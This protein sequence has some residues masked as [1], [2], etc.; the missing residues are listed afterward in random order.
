MNYSRA[1]L[2]RK[3]RAL[4]GK[5]RRRI[6]KLNIIVCI[7]LITS[8][9][10]VVSLGINMGLGTLQGI[11]ASAPEI[12]KI[13]VTPSGFSTFV[14]DTQG[15]QTAKLV[16]SDA[17]RIPVA[18]DQVPL[19]LQ[20]A[21]VAIEDERFYEHN[22]IDIRGIFR[23]AAE[24]FSSG[25]FSQG[26]STI[27]Q[28]LLKNNVFDGWTDETFME[29]VCRKV[30]EWYLATE[31]EKT[32]SKDD[33]LINYMNTINLGHNTLGV[34][35]ASLR[36]FDKDVSALTLSECAVIA[37]ITQNPSRYDPIVYPENN[38]AKR[39]IVLENM[40]NQGY[41]TQE[42]YEDA[43]ADDV[44]SRIKQVDYRTDDNAIQSYFVDA[45][46]E[47]LLEDLQKAGYTEQQAFTLL[48]S[49]GLSI[50]ST[51]DP[52]IQ[53][54]CDTVTSDP[55][56]YPS[57]TRYYLNYQLTTQNADGEL[58]NYSS[59]MLA[60]YFK[61]QNSLFSLLF[62]SEE[63]AQARADEYREHI[64]SSGET[65]VSESINLAPQPQISLTI[66]DQS[67]GY[68]VAMVGG[69]GEKKAN[70]T[71]N[72]AYSSMR[73]PG[74]TFKVVS[75]YAPA[76]DAAG[77]GLATI[78]YDEPY[79]YDNG[80]PVRNWYGEAYRG[81]CTLRQGITSSLNIVTV[82]LLERIGVQTGFDYLQSFGFTTLVD[83]ATIHGQ[84]FTDKQLT[85]AL[86]GLT[87]G[88]KNYELNAAY[89]TI[90][91]GGIYKEPKLY[92]KVVD[93]SGNVIL[94]ADE[95]REEHRVLKE[96]SAWLLTSAMM[97]VVTSGTGTMVNF[98]TTA[99]AGKT[100]TTSDEN[101]VWFAGY[102]PD[103]TCTTWAGFDENTDLTSS[104]EIALAKT[105]WRKVMQEIPAN[106]ER[107]E[108][109]MPDS[110]SRVTVCSVSGQLPREGCSSL[111]TE[112]ADPSELHYCEVHYNA[113]IC[114][115]SGKIAN[116]QCPYRST[117][118]SGFDPDIAGAVCNHT[119]EYLATDEGQ[120][121][122]AAEMRRKAER[123]GHS[124][125]KQLEEAQET[126]AENQAVLE[127]AQAAL[128]AAQ[129]AGDTAA[130]EQ[131]TALFYA[132][133][134]G[135][136]QSYAA[137]VEIVES[138]QEDNP[139]AASEITIDPQ[140]AADEQAAAAAAA[141]AAVEAQAT[142]EAAAFAQA[143]ASPAQ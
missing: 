86:G 80:T 57:G 51:Q 72:R 10:G 132:A 116:D 136:Q 111:T 45:L 33:I 137:V 7:L 52:E 130:I 78:Q 138:M 103:Y 50:Y 83:E 94:E 106:Q 8:V 79:T 2:S 91:N 73:Q 63:E 20:H 32:M 81:A 59:E 47:Q 96:S 121:Q 122:L 12:D 17:N 29:S 97:D 22:G 38:N 35:A 42:E 113:P 39:L 110:V 74:S 15:N 30:Q 43:C 141:Q 64:L 23:A 4:S 101:D 48:Y 131:Y 125:E 28:Q 75:S 3:E 70:R 16:S 40:K 93:H 62:S 65:L 95:I 60:S 18:L 1:G 102:T 117:D 129:Q 88:V 105:I 5:L 89:A 19:N 54:I 21:F 24:G 124:K 41:I 104:A 120:I 143:A 61:S 77:L 31:L 26:A 135:Y 87:Y 44:Y 9:I 55:E 84:S 112:Y 68:I 13:D 58:C 66:E 11:L 46:T 99:I 115:A 126:L 90:A 109:E 118:N 114:T 36:Y 6:N 98:G 56:N 53:E 85:L 108:F 100:G 37:G 69:R 71:L 119:P 133:A 14:Y 67:T 123:E 142:A 128:L 92:S 27:T 82:K 139:D 34:Q 107:K 134:E 25:D 49:G 140:T 76:I 127:Q